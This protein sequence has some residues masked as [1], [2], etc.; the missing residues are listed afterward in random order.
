MSC[1]RLISITIE[2]ERVFLTLRKRIVI[3]IRFIHKDKAT[4]WEIDAVGQR[5]VIDYKERIKA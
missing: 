1:R 4:E 2:T 3:E 5:E